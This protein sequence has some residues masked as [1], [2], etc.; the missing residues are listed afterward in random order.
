MGR[1]CY[2]VGGTSTLR[3]FL[4]SL[5]VFL[6]IAVVATSFCTGRYCIGYHCS[7]SCS[8]SGT[9]D[10]GAGSD[11]EALRGTDADEESVEFH[12][13]IV[14]L[15]CIPKHR[16][17]FRRRCRRKCGA[18]HGCTAVMCTVNIVLGAIAVTSSVSGITTSSMYF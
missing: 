2:Y 15:C 11:F 9:T 8:D 4:I 13:V 17:A 1:A 5:G 7:D 16:P 18:L 14:E 6:A 10:A 12:D 3:G